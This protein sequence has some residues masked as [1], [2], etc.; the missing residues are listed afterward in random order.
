NVPYDSTSIIATILRWKG[1]DPQLPKPGDT[2]NRP[3]LGQRVASAPTFENVLTRTE[4][5]TDLPVLLDPPMDAL[6]PITIRNDTPAQIY[7]YLGWGPDSGPLKH[8]KLPTTI[9]GSTMFS[10]GFPGCLDPGQ[11][12][13]YDTAARPAGGLFDYWVQAS[14][15]TGPG[16][17]T[18][19]EW[20]DSALGLN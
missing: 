6:E 20:V 12:A 15:Y 11:I 10:G 7:V 16:S 17:N 8:R 14:Y 18:P 4:P 2:S 13:T 3:W 19:P 9:W 1:I 5:R